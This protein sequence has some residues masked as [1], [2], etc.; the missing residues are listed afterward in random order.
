MTIENR[1]KHKYYSYVI[2]ANKYKL[3]CLIKTA[4]VFKVIS[5]VDQ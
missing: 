2:K 5:N 4:E 3:N 1:N